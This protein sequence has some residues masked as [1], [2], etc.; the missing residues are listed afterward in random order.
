MYNLRSFLSAFKKLRF[1]IYTPGTGPYI[2]SWGLVIFARDTREILVSLCL[3][4][5]GWCVRP[6]HSGAGFG[7]L[8][9]DG[10]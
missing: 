3:T 7:I 5:D 2:G 9:E 1:R 6:L 4:S 10:A 8:W